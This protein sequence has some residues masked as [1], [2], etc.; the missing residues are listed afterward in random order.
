MPINKII[1]LAIFSILILFFSS[2]GKNPEKKG[3]KHEVE[4]NIGI[5]LSQNSAL[6]V[7][8]YIFSGLAVKLNK[9][10][11][12]EII[13]KS[14]EKSWIGSLQ[15]YWYKA[16]MNN[17]ITGWVFGKNIKIVKSKDDSDVSKFVSEFFKDESNSLKK[18]IAGK[19]WSINKFEDFTE[20]AL[21]FTPDGKYK[22]YKNQQDPTYI[23][24]EYKI[25][26]QNSEILFEKGTTFGENLKFAPRGKTYVLY[27]ELKTGEMVFKKI[28]LET[29]KKESGKSEK[30]DK[31]EKIQNNDE[32][33]TK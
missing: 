21:E 24:G 29:T 26:F 3:S 13:D 7:D 1:P 32:D 5:V 4:K 12:V 6:R 9:G 11:T 8:P 16:R 10:D 22:S 31:S 17:G 27:K 2:C 14:S 18:E 19:W 28:S 33:K 20:D 15:D 23:D 30:T 25:D